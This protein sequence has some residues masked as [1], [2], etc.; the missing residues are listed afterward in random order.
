MRHISSEEFHLGWKRQLPLS[1]RVDCADFPL[2]VRLFM[3]S[4]SHCCGHTNSFHTCV[5]V[6]FM[7]HCARGQRRWSTQRLLKKQMNEEHKWFPPHLGQAPPFSCCSAMLVSLHT[8]ETFTDSC[9][10]T[11]Q[12]VTIVAYVSF[13]MR[14]S[15]ATGNTDVTTENTKVIFDEDYIWTSFRSN[16]PMLGSRSLGSSSFDFW[17]IDWWIANLFKPVGYISYLFSLMVSFQN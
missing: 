7:T 16:A 11:L 15:A 1:R 17:L 9:A 12:W 5:C 6:C 3:W 10:A 4:Q 14:E 13:I 2:T 8:C